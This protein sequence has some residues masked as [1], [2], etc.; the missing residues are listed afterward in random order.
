MGISSNFENMAKKIQEYARLNDKV[1]QA[2]LSEQVTKTGNHK[3]RQAA[4]PVQADTSLQNMQ[5]LY[6][7][8]LQ[9]EKVCDQACK[10]LKEEFNKIKNQN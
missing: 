1:A 8:V 5:E 9:L 2:Y 4:F 6:E 10:E 7:M 3:I